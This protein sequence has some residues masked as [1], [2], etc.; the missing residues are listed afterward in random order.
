MIDDYSRKV[1]M[2]LLKTKD[3]TLSKFIERKNLVEIRIG[4]KLRTLRTDNGLEYLSQQF[5]SFY[6]KERIARHKT[7]VGTLQQNGCK[8]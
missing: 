3:Q 7:I 8:I 2:Y 6:S 1:W 4:R 5:Q